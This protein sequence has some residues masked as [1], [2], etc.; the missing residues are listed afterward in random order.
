MEDVALLE[1]E[2]SPAS[3]VN[4]LGYADAPRRGTVLEQYLR[5]RAGRTKPHVVEHE[6][7]PDAAVIPTP[8]RIKCRELC[9]RFG[10]IA[11]FALAVAGIVWLWP[12]R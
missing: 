6:L 3:L 11:V 5:S 7:P 9:V 4:E 2:A 8:A 12:S 1:T 10:A